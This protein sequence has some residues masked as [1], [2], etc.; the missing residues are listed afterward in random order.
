ML[1]LG[2]ASVIHLAENKPRSFATLRMTDRFFRRPAAFGLI[3]MLALPLFLALPAYGAAGEDSAPVKLLIS[4]EHQSIVAPFPARVTL[5][6]HTAGQ[7]SL[8]FYRRARPRPEGGEVVN[9]STLAVHLEP[10][11]VPA[12]RPVRVAAEG[13]VLESVGLPRPKLVKLEPGDDYEEKAVV[14]LEPARAGEEGAG[15]PLWGRYRFS[16]TYG[17]RYANAEVISRS[18]ALRPWQGE[19]TSN[20]IE[21][22][23]LPPTGQGS[24]SGRVINAVGEYLADARVSL[25]DEQERLV[26]QVV[27]G[28]EGRFSFAHLPFGVYWV[29]SRLQRAA[30]DT[31]AFRHVELPPAAPESK[32]DLVYIPPEVFK[33]EQRLHKPVLFRVLD[34]AGHPF[35]DATLAISFM[36]GTVLEDKKLKV[37]DD[38]TVATELIPGS[39]FVTLKRRGCAPQELRLEVAPGDGIDA[40]KLVTDCA[41]R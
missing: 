11:G 32:I 20:S 29:T 34:E 17:A 10:I 14:H 26:D 7:E 27:T 28:F 15:Q 25:S 5:H 39:N 22:E 40:F 37:T 23:L 19:V 30:Y 13:T 41:A 35:G 24:L 38:G 36:N 21:V 33:G 31:A 12:S 8:W 2:E 1:S 4:I 16:V 9:G 3:W 6:L 18:V